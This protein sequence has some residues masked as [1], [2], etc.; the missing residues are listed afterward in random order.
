M[1]EFIFQTKRILPQKALKLYV[2]I[3]YHKS[4]WLIRSLKPSFSYWPFVVAKVCLKVWISSCSNYWNFKSIVVWPRNCCNPCFVAIVLIIQELDSK[5]TNSVTFWRL[6]VLVAFNYYLPIYSTLMSWFDLV[7]GFDRVTGRLH[8]N[9]N[10]KMLSRHRDLNS[11]C[12]QLY[13]NFQNFL[14]MW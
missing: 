6:S 1:I 7:E 5:L 12:P 8:M 14:L 2:R 3:L 11:Q 10:G 13:L 4:L 9:F